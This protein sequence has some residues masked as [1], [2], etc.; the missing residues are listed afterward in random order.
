[1]GRTEGLQII[2][3]G[4][5]RGVFIRKDD[6]GHTATIHWGW[7]E[8]SE[9]E[10]LSGG[11]LLETPVVAIV[12]SIR[13][14]THDWIMDFWAKSFARRCLLERKMGFSCTQDL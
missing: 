13:K 14:R 2:L 10:S 4:P 5:D 11:M 12:W 3:F 1:M 7:S 6:E 9:W 8:P